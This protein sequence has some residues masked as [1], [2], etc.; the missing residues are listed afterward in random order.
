[1]SGECSVVIATRN[2]APVL[3]ETLTRLYELP[4][5]PRVFVVDNASSDETERVW[6]PFANRVEFIKLRRNIGAAARTVGARFAQSPYVAFCDDDCYW[7]P[8]SLARAT[9]LFAIH[10]DVAVLNGRVLVGD[11]AKDDPACQAMGAGAVPSPSGGVPIVYFMAGACVM[12][13][14]AF[15]EVGGYDARYFIGAEE[16]LLSLDLATR[17]WKLWYCNDLLLLHRPSAMNRDPELRRRL[18]LRNRL[19]TLL[20]R[21]SV[22]STLRAIGQY[23]RTSARDA[24]VR[25][26]LAEAIAALPWIVRERRTVPRELE[27]QARAL[28]RVLAP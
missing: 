24:A 12:R 16:S 7:L 6:K 3:R 5:R 4:E 2:R 19:W 28:D 17:G 10:Q 9:E 18:V 20:L 14:R 23:L 13:R 27:I 26:A 22:P 1:M 25:A 8:G 21:R 11:Q 15:L